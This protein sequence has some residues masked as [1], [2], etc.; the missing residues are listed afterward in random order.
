MQG[1]GVG[2]Q[3]FMS[4]QASAKNCATNLNC[5]LTLVSEATAWGGYSGIEYTFD[6]WFNDEQVRHVVVDGV[7]HSPNFGSGF[8]LFERVW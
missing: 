1:Q 5:N 6:Y 3:E 8:N 4:A 2:N 7:G